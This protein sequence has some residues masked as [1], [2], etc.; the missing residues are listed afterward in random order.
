MKHERVHTIYQGE[1]Y[2]DSRCF[3]PFAGSGISFEFILPHTAWY[4]PR[5]GDYY[6]PHNLNPAPLNKLVGFREGLRKMAG[7]GAW[8][9]AV[10]GWRPDWKH[11][12]EGGEKR[13][14]VFPYVHFNGDNKGGENPEPIIHVPLGHGVK[15]EIQTSGSRYYFTVGGM[16][17]STPRHGPTQLGWLKFMHWPYFGGPDLAPHDMMIFLDIRYSLF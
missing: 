16:P 6:L 2:S 17:A 5:N 10:L 14:L 12:N 1:H 13:A 4:E 11:W 9:S 3:L 15:G 8:D 7:G